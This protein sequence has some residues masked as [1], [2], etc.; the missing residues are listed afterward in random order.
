MF[1]SNAEL[2]D[3]PSH[4]A[5]FINTEPIYRLVHVI[6]VREH[7]AFFSPILSASF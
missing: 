7:S 1:L 4:N 3:S 2:M 6:A 5:M